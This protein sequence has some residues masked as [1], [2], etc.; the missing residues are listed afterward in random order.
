VAHV[1]PAVT[2]YDLRIGRRR[3]LPVWIGRL[4]PAGLGWFLVIQGRKVTA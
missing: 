3:Y 4:V 2:P 1:T